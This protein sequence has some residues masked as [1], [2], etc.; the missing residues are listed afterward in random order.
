MSD[1][2]KDNYCA[3]GGG[4]EAFHRAPGPALALRRVHTMA[5]EYPEGCSCG[6]SEWNGMVDHIEWCRTTIDHLRQFAGELITEAREL[7]GCGRWLEG[8]KILSIALELEHK[9]SLPNDRIT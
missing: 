8:E 3:P 6:S 7:K 4:P 5:C 2:N 9:L 1:Q